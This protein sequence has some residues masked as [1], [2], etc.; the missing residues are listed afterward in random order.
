M[1]ESAVGGFVNFTNLKK[2][3]QPAI[4]ALL[5]DKMIDE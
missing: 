2:E 4:I 1:S 3:S 5:N